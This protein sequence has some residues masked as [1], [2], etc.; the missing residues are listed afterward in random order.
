LKLSATSFYAGGNLNRY[1]IY[2]SF[3]WIN[4]AVTD[5]DYDTFSYAIHDDHWNALADGKFNIYYGDFLVNTLSRPSQV[6]FSARS[7]KMRSGQYALKGPYNG[8]ACMIARN[9]TA[10]IDN[11]IIIN[12]SQDLIGGLSISF[13]VFSISVRGATNSAGEEVRF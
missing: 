5:V 7:Y 4:G 2:P 13:G 1:Y 3:A 10:P 9:T 8:T 12:Y 11:R 6:G